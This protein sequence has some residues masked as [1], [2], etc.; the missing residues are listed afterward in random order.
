MG[1]TVIEAVAISILNL[2]SAGQMAALPI[3]ASA[4]SLVELILTQLVINARYSLMSISL[5]SQLDKSITTKDR[6]LLAF[7]VTDEMFAVAIGKNQKLGKKYLFTLMILPIFGWAFGTLCGAIAGNILPEVIVTALSVSMYAMFIA[8]I[9]PPAKTSLSLA[10]AILTSIT[11]SCMLEYLP[12]VSSIP[13]GFAIIIS[14]VVASVILAIISP[15]HDQ[16]VE[17]DE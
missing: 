6:L 8:I 13:D 10:G 11:I 9:V 17:D 14:A 16:E 12:V 1:L 5:S 7:T 4:G 15:I 3:I 2:T